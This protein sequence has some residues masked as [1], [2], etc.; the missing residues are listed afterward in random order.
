MLR[1]RGN[2]QLDWAVRTLQL[3][4]IQE[5]IFLKLATTGR[6]ASPIN[7]CHP[8]DPDSVDPA[9]LL[10]RIS[11][12]LLP[13]TSTM[14]QNTAQILLL[15]LHPASPT[16]LNLLILVLM[17]LLAPSHLHHLP[18]TIGVQEMSARI[19]GTQKKMEDFQENLAVPE[20]QRNGIDIKTSEVESQNLGSIDPTNDLQYPLTREK[21]EVHHRMIGTERKAEDP[22][23]SLSELGDIDE[24]IYGGT[25]ILQKDDRYYITLM[26]DE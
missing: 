23:M 5:Q 16:S 21:Q 22:I 6:Q 11:V 4:V 17:A 14:P 3:L 2:L 9:V 8:L 26:I 18:L 24:Q 1:M 19:G 25:M 10:S 13:T 15:P 7:T 20:K 12:T